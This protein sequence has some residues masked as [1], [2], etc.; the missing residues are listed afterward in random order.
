MSKRIVIF[1]RYL[2][3]ALALAVVLYIISQ[4]VVT[5]RTIKYNL[6]FSESIT[7]D[8]T[9]WYPEVRTSFLNGGLELK[10]EP[11]YLKIYS[12]IDFKNLKIKGSLNFNEE[13]VRLGLK[14]SDSTWYF[15]NITEENFSLVF[16]L[17]EAQV[18]RNKLELILSIPDLKSDSGIYLNNDWQ[19]ELQR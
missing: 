9:G 12:P 18:K 2:W 8:I 19:V 4:A 7:R 16:D 13:D 5:S 11:L 10:S 3:I 6:D 15:K 1:F 14:Q 17:S